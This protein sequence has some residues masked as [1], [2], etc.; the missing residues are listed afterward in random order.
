MYQLIDQY[1]YLLK[2]LTFHN[3]IIHIKSV[4]NKNKNE[5]QYIF[6]KRFIQ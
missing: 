2:T 1:F 3:D 5:Y 4:V 6:R